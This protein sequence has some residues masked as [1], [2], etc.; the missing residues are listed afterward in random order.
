MGY[1]GYMYLKKSR[2]W[3]CFSQGQRFAVLEEKL[4]LAHV[5]HNFSI[6]S[7]QTFDELQ[8]CT[9]MITRPREGIFVSLAKRQ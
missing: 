3:F 5:L 7:T 2:F 9:E 6:E 4:V 8:T 1:M